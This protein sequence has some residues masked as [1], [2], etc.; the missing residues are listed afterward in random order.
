[1]S[2]AVNRSARVPGRIARGALLALLVATV[3]HAADGPA[4]S[5]SPAAAA[6]L[7]AYV[8]VPTSAPAHEPETRL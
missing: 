3:A 8:S 4:P 5:P 7:P 6:A 1:M 2:R